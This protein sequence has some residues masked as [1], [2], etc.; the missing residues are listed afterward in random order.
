MVPNSIEAISGNNQ[1]H[2]YSQTA[3]GFGNSSNPLF[4][5]D[6]LAG[7][8]SSEDDPMTDEEEEDTTCPIIRLSSVE[9][10]M[11]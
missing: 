10:R 5:G 7:E 11:P 6:A 4:E 1:Q 3:K 8:Y 9:K 2:S